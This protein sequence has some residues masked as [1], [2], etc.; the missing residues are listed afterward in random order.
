M[1]TLQCEHDNNEPEHF[2]VLDYILQLAENGRYSVIEEYIKD[3]DTKGV[4]HLFKYY[5]NFGTGFFG[6]M[7]AEIIRRV[8]IPKIYCE[9][10]GCTELL[11]GHNKRGE[12]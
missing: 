3:L 2:T 9:T 4:L 8:S 5:N 6:L 7:E 11:C 10:C 12:K 1:L